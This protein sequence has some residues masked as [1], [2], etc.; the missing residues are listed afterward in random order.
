MS[1]EKVLDFVR[2]KSIVNGS[3]FVSIHLSVLSAALD[4]AFLQGR[5]TALTSDEVQRGNHEI[6]P[7]HFGSIQ[8]IEF[9]IEA[10]ERDFAQYDV[11]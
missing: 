4:L 11:L 9:H 1:N 8:N 3:D 7:K 2:N 10:I 5:L 6:N